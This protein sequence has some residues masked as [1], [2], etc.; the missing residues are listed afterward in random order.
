MKWGKFRL[1]LRTLK[2]ALS[3]MICLILFRFFE[4]DSGNYAISAMI[5]SLSAVFSLRQDINQTVKLGKARL[6]GNA[7]GGLIA[8]VYTLLQQ[9]IHH[10]V[11]LEIIGVPLLVIVLIV[12]SDALNN[13]TGIIGATSTLLIIALTIPK[14]QSLAYT[15]LRV[16]DTFVGIFIAFLVN[17]FI[18]PQ[19]PEEKFKRSMKM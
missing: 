17:R 9:V 19:Q 14:N 10:S 2:T 8:L 18:K 7:L 5:A 12:I 4:K 13:N 15:A 11:L 6:F 1:G 3:V 16:L